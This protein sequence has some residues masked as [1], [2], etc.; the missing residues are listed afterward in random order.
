VN[1]APPP[2]PEPQLPA[3]RPFGSITLPSGPLPVPPPT[4]GAPRAAPAR[5]Q[6]GRVRLPPLSIAALRAARRPD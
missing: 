4:A 3:R 1:T 2:P 6:T 5:W